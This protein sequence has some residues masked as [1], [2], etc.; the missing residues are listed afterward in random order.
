MILM[1]S[2][3]LSTPD[4]KKINIFQNKD[5]DAIIFNFNNKI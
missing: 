3:K 5:Y 2:A 1:M 4:L